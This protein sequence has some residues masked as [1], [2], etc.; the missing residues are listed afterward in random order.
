MKVSPSGQKAYVGTPRGTSGIPVSPNKFYI[1]S[2]WVY[3]PSENTQRAKLR[4]IWWDRDGN[5]LRSEDSY[6]AAKGE[7]QYLSVTAYANYNAAYASLQLRGT[8]TYAADDVFYLDAAQFEAGRFPTSY[9]PTTDGTATRIAER[10]T[11]PTSGNLQ[12]AQG[13]LSLWVNPEY[14]PSTAQTRTFFDARTPGGN[15]MR[16]YRNTTDKLVLQIGDDTNKKETV[17]SGIMNWRENTWH[18]IVATWDR[19]RQKVFVDGTLIASTTAPVLP[20]QFNDDFSLGDSRDASTP[21]A[22][23]FADV[24]IYDRVLSGT[25]ISTLYTRT[26]PPH[27]LTGAT[28]FA[29]FDQHTDAYTR[30]ILSPEPTLTAGSEET[31]GTPWWYRAAIQ[32]VYDPVGN[33]IKRLDANGH[34]L[35]YTYDKLNQLTRV[36]YPKGVDDAFIYDALSRRTSVTDAIGTV[37]YQYDAVGRI[38][39]VTYPG[40]KTVRYKYDTV[41]RRVQMTDPDG[42]VTHYTY[43]LASQLTSITDPQ[44]LTTRYTYDAAQRLTQMTLGNGIKTCYT[45]NDAN[46]LIKVEHRKSDDT[47]IHRFDYVRDAVGN[48][49]RLTEANGNYTDYTYDDVY[50]LRSEMKKDT[51][52]TEVSNYAYTYDKLGNRLTMTRDGQTTRYTYDTSNRLLTAGTLGFEYDANGN[53]TR[54]TDNTEPTNPLVTQYHYDYRNHLTQI[55][56]PDGTKNYFQYGA[57]GVRQSKRDATSAVQFI[58]DGLNVIQEVS[59]M[60]GQTAAEYLHGPLGVIKQRLGTQDQWYLLD[61]LGSTAALT[62]AKQNATDTY[63]YE[64]FGNKGTTTGTTVNPYKYVAGSGY[65]TD[66]ESDLMLLTLRYYDAAL[67]RFIT[68]D[69]ASVGPNLYAYASN[70]P[71]KYVDPIGLRE[72]TDEEIRL[73]RQIFGDKIDYSKVRIYTSGSISRYLCREDIPGLTLYNS[74]FFPSDDFSDSLLI[75]ELVHVWQFNK[76][77]LDLIG[78]GLTH[79]IA[80]KIGKTLELYKY[81]LYAKKPFQDYGFEEQAQILQDVYRVVYEGK[82]PLGYDLN[83]ITDAVKDR[84]RELH[85]QFKK[86][87]H[88]VRATYPPK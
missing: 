76:R 66:D 36:Q 18:H 42:G 85:E 48:R 72:M 31:T 15:G 20:T 68:R 49:T 5:L 38:I 17:S 43:D 11:Y 34:T 74:I 30:T 86:W 47:L 16:L 35:R 21:A 63:T 3:V 2:G 60:T 1:Y 57:D 45:Y 33:V 75:H 46:A 4:V 40:N 55:T 27:A 59:N 24:A 87:H 19:E 88:R 61:G 44:N 10:L 29:D 23:T 32:A 58:Y 14:G 26:A 41:G 8:D 7:W 28:F 6:V 39:R 62:D 78:A 71:L 9:I 79:F 73:A 69:P 51:S 65:Y 56:Y 64:G 80:D 12:T 37:T 50:Q 13:S 54:R 67:G 81:D 25:E 82:K 70:N 52:D 53:M 83:Y 22:A 77:R 84:Y